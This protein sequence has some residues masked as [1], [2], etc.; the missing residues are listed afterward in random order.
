MNNNFC[1]NCGAQLTNRGTGSQNFC[2][3]C[4]TRI[5]ANY[6]NSPAQTFNMMSAYKSMFK[7]YS[8]FNGR[9]RRSEYWYATLLNSLICFA[10]WLIIVIASISN[11]G[12]IS[13]GTGIF[14]GF[15]GIIFGI[16]GIAVIIPGLAMAVRRLHDTGRSGWFMLIGLIPYIGAI[17]LLIFMC[18]DSQPGANKYGTNPKEGIAVSKIWGD[19]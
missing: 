17:I 2:P 12:Y 11:D 15:V 5:T 8:Q 18:Q 10:A 14:I 7:K 9:S 6:E 1:P 16:Y 19:I 13:D 3:G 4:G